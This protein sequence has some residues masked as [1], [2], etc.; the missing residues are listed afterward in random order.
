MSRF[1]LT[2]YLYYPN[3]DI[4]I[5][6]FLNKEIN[7]I[8]IENKISFEDFISYCRGNINNIE[9]IFHNYIA[10]PKNKIIYIN[11]NYEDSNHD[12]EEIISYN[13]LQLSNLK[14][15]G[16]DYCLFFH[17]GV[18][19]KIRLFEY[20]MFRIENEDSDL[21]YVFDEDHKYFRE[22]DGRS[23]EDVYKILSKVKEII[24]DHEDEMINISDFS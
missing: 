19:H 22:N 11:I 4:K 14:Y 3:Y 17:E 12:S 7:S 9:E 2:Q 10:D 20:L 18:F 15:I 13:N 24:E 21:F 5:I 8:V 16:R 6:L 1:D 23:D